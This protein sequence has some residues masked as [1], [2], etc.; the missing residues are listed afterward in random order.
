MAIDRISAASAEARSEPVVEL[1]MYRSTPPATLLATAHGM[2]TYAALMTFVLGYAAAW[3]FFKLHR[4]P[5]YIPGAGFSK[6]RARPAGRR[7]LI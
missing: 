5:P 4:M 6:G 1:E 7:P 2:L 3:F